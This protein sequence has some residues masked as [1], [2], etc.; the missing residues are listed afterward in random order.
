MVG[1]EQVILVDGILRKDFGQLQGCIENNWV[2]NFRYDDD[3]LIG[4]F[5][6]VYIEQVL[7]NLLLGC[8]CEMVEDNL[9]LMLS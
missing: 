2:V 8:F 1:S 7:L 9:E 5:V 3:E 6:K 4:C